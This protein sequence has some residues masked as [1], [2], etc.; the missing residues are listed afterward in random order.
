MN[1]KAT[2][3]IISIRNNEKRTYAERYWASLVYGG[4][5]PMA[6]NYDISAM[7]A[8]A[9]RLRLEEFAK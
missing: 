7:A 1:P 4:R 3:Y 2:K 8:Q 6:D 5:A 9:V